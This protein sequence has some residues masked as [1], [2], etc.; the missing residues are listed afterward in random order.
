[1]HLAECRFFAWFGHPSLRIREDLVT[2]SE[3]AHFDVLMLL[4]GTSH[5]W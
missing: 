5:E 2:L 3:A 4:T 1:M